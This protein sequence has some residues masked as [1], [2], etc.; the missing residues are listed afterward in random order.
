MAKNP[1]PSGRPR[2]AD[3][4]QYLPIA[5]PPRDGYLTPGLRPKSGLV[6][7]L[8]FHAQIIKDNPAD[9]DTNDRR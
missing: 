8:G 4:Y 5:R 6:A 2:P 9:E 7:A 3:R 1:H